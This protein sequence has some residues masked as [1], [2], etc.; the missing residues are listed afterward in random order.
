MAEARRAAR[1]P[2]RQRGRVVISG[3]P[4]IPCTIKD[5]SSL[6]ARLSFMNP[7]I[8][9]RNF[10]LLFEDQDQKVRVIWQ[11]GL[12]A[13]VR[14]QAPIRALAGSAPAKRGWPWSKK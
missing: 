12:L 3:R 2:A 6:G 4:E 5:L 1:S 9:P 7:T 11:A 14:F 13:G 8:L 10:R